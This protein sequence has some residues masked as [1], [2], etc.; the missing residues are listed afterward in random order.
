[1]LYEIMLYY[2]VLYIYYITLCYIVRIQGLDS[3][4]VEGVLSLRFCTAGPAR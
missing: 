4:L 3:S 2:I 1:M